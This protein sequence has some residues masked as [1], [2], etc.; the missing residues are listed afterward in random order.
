MKLSTRSLLVITPVVLLSFFM[1]S[2]IVYGQAER[3]V[4]SQEQDR[5]RYSVNRLNALFNQYTTFAEIYLHSVVE[6][7]AFR[8]YLAADGDAAS[9]TALAQS[10]EDSRDQLGGQQSFGLLNISIA[11]PASGTSSHFELSG[12]SVLGQ[13]P[14]QNEILLSMTP[15]DDSQRW[16]YLLSPSSSTDLIDTI[17][18]TRLVDGSEPGVSLPG[19]KGPFRTVQLAVKPNDFIARQEQLRNDVGASFVLTRTPP[20]DR[21]LQAFVELGDG[22][23][24]V[25]TLPPQHLQQQLRPLLGTLALTCLLFAMVVSLSLHFLM[26]RYVTLPVS[27]LEQNLTDL[28]QR[29][30]RTIQVPPGNDEISRLAGTFRTFYEDL[31]LAYEETR[32]LMQHDN[33][34]GLYNLGHITTLARNAIS[35]ASIMGEEVALAYLDIDNFKYIN[36]KYGHHLGNE[37][38]VG[39]ANMLSNTR[40]RVHETDHQ[41]QPFIA[42][43]RV[44]GDQFCL[45]IRHE[46]AF[47]VMHGLAESLISQLAEGMSVARGRFPMT[48]SIGIASFPHDA[49]NVQQ[50][51]SFA[52]TAMHQAKHQGKHRIAFYSP[53]LASAQQRRQEI[54]TEL[55][56]LN[57]DEEF[58]LVYMPLLNMRNDELDGFEALLRWESPRL[59]SI[60]PDEFVPIAEACG[61]F[62]VID[63][64]VIRTGLSTY[65]TL[66]NML[67]RDFKMSLNISSAQL[68]L[69]NLVETLGRY[70]RRF[71]I[72]A[73]CVQ[74]EITETMNVE[75]TN[76]AHTLLGNLSKLG[77]QLALDDFG[78]GFTSLA[79]LVEYPIDMV[80]FDKSFIQQ[81]LKRGNRQ[82]LR[83]LVD[84]CHSHGMLVTMEGAETQEDIDLLRSFDCDYVQGYFLGR[85]IALDGIEDILRQLKSG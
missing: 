72:P 17:V 4:H 21:P 39:F 29:K 13:S 77:Y 26:R 80:K 42:T 53:A 66:R 59:G 47:L 28:V 85:P 10:L 74:L 23:Y 54:E 48:V 33:L 84:L 1:A 60:E 38:L 45:M 30:T 83:P 8:E 51:M 78:A 40:T 2:L 27:R 14:L 75:Y 63:E 82:I 50:L 71:E 73:N 62:A 35:E 20:Q 34:T 3:L 41:Q 22:Q 69:S 52:D 6:S 18:L 49:D 67:G 43:A 32:R 56:T 61:L 25:G 5:L 24:L 81:T 76:Y 31:S 36:D 64:W 65:P 57:P 19:Q 12:N 9:E 79:R 7:H 58:Q 37:L 68:Q 55:K 11:H 70:T 15:G 46:D 16:D 44:A